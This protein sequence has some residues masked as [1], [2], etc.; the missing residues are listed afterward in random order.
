MGRSN[1]SFIDFMTDQKLSRQ[2]T[3]ERLEVY[4]KVFSLDPER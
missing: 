1:N 2:L 3:L 4:T